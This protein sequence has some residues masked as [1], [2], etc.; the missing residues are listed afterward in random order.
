MNFEKLV[1]EIKRQKA[2][3][4]DT[5][6]G[7][8]P[9]M[10]AARLGRKLTAKLRLDDL[11]FNYREAVRPRVLFILAVGEGSDQFAKMAK[12]TE[13]DVSSLPF[14][15]LVQKMTEKTD[16][17]LY[18]K[19]ERNST[20]LD[21]GNRILAEVALELGVRSYNFMNFKQQYEGR[22]SKAEDVYDLYFRAIKDQVG[23]E[24]LALYLADHASRLAFKENFDGKV[25]PLIV[26][27]RPDM[28]DIA[29]S[30][31][32]KSGNMYRIVAVNTKIKDSAANLEEVNE[33]SVVK[34]L[35]KVRKS[36][37]KEK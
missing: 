12:E 7:I 14:D 11:F 36:L 17:R 8:D 21:V 33:E 25:Y 6:E 35:I 5:L 15:S 20:V 2:Y 31:F 10:R 27:V 3:A 26:T 16:K 1:Q 22:S 13:A 4:A 19:G 30:A 18:E 28:L 23:S 29:R 34:A 32:A 37:S 24:M 9:K